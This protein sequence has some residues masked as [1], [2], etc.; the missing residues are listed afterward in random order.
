MSCDLKDDG[1]QA[2]GVY[3][4]DITLQKNYFEH[5]VKLIGKLSIY[6]KC[7]YTIHF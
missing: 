2:N 7:E 3:R 6:F 1:Y 4:N 5:Y